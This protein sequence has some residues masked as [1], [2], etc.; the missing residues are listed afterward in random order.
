[1]I[2]VFRKTPTEVLD[3]DFTWELE[4]DET[5]VTST[6]AA[7]GTGLTIG[8][9]LVSGATVKVWLSGGTL[10]ASYT[11]TNTITTSDGRT[12]QDSFSMLIRAA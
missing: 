2:P 10:G 3:Y 4:D 8:M 6:W 9:T 7:T 11:V 5:I 12:L 1:M